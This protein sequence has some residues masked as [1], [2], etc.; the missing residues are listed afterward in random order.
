[1]DGRIVSSYFGYFTV[2]GSLQR[3]LEFS[4]WYKENPQNFAQPLG[5]SQGGVP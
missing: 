2:E 4:F 5:V 1:M 3:G